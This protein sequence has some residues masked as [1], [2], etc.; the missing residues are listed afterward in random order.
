MLG[1]AQGVQ[2]RVLLPGEDGGSGGQISLGT[3]G[4]MRRCTIQ[5][6]AGREGAI[7]GVL[8]ANLVTATFS[9]ASSGPEATVLLLWGGA[10]WHGW[11]GPRGQRGLGGL[12][13][14]HLPPGVG[15]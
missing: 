3:V 10:G 15:E 14:Q 9:P 6:D 13:P 11:G 12:L 1:K 4:Q 7:Q 8:L 2:C 5:S